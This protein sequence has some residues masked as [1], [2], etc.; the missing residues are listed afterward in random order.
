MASLLG[1]YQ[2]PNK[3]QTIIK[4]N[5]GVEHQYEAKVENKEIILDSKNVVLYRDRK[6]VCSIKSELMISEQNTVKNEFSIVKD[7]SVAANKDDSLSFVKSTV[8]RKPDSKHAVCDVCSKTFSNKY[9]LKTHKK[10]PRGCNPKG[11]VKIVNFVTC[12]TCGQD[13]KAKRILRHERLCRML[14]DERAAYY[15][16]TKVE[17]EKCHKILSARHKLVR[18]IKTVHNNRKEFQCE[19]CEH[20]DNRSDNMKTHMKNNHSKLQND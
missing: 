5:H 15:A 2:P 8:T 11:N 10:S 9:I 1:I 4:E 13:K 17:C 14:D 3:F 12:I 16:R 18:H 6:K 20:K 19:Y 7:D